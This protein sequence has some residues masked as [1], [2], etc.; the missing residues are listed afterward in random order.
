MRLLYN[1]A[2]EYHQ[3]SVRLNNDKDHSLD[4]AKMLA[5][6]AVKNYHPHDFSLLHKRDGKIYKAISKDAK[7][8]YVKTAIEKKIAEREQLYL[9]KLQTFDHTCHASA[10]ELRLAYL[11]HIVSHVSV[12]ITS[13][14]IDN[15]AKSFIEIAS[16][17]EDFNQILQ[18]STI[19]Y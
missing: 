9:E 5:M 19:T 15:K 7:R 18:K 11:M 16:S 6:I 2:N 3:Y 12:A 8:L 1:I 17:Q 4:S 14:V 10:T 13:I